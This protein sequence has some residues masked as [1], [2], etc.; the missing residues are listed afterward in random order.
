MFWHVLTKDWIPQDRFRT[1]GVGQPAC[2]LCNKSHTG[3]TW[4]WA[5][6]LTASISVWSDLDCCMHTGHTPM[7]PNTTTTAADTVSSLSSLIFITT[8][9]SALA[10]SLIIVIIIVYHDRVGH[11][12]SCSYMLHVWK[13]TQHHRTHVTRVTLRQGPS[14]RPLKL[15]QC[16]S[17]CGLNWAVAQWFERWSSNE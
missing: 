8:V 15:Y 12:K 3:V 2:L 4:V 7:K 5:I 14:D 1:G 17:R 6:L 10:S 13:F 9:M 11:G 16:L